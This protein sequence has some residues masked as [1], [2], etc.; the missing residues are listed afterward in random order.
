MATGMAVFLAGYA[1]YS[2]FLGGIDG[3][4]VLPAMF[5]PGERSMDAVVA[6]IPEG[7]AETKIKWSFGNESPEAKRQIKLD[8]RSK[9]LLLAADRFDI[10]EGRVKLSPFSAALFGKN[11]GDGL[12]PEINT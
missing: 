2:Y 5:L 4:Q 6:S 9:R 3:L 11:Q 10:E 12:F 8:L 1:V 7:E